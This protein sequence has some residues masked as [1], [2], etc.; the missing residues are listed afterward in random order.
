MDVEKKI[1]STISSRLGQ[2]IK[3]LGNLEGR[4]NLIIDGQVEGNI[5]LKGHC[6]IISASAWIKGNVDAREV[7]L[8]GKMEGNIVASDKVAIL[9]SAFLIGDITACRVSIQD[10]AKFKGT[11]KIVPTS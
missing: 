9:A 5:D 2:A 7:V 11:I 4:E 1:E 8:E 6:L 10:G 3:I